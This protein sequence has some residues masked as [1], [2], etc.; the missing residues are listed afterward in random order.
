MFN[1]SLNNPTKGRLIESYKNGANWY[2]IYSDGWCEQGGR[3]TDGIINFLKPF[4]DTNY[5][6]CG[7]NTNASSSAAFRFYNLANDY[8]YLACSQPCSWQACGYIS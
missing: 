7:A 1:T 3:A 8:V 2:R 4:S 5:T 6:I